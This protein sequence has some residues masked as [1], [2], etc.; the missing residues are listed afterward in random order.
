[1]VELEK[2]L[3]CYEDLGRQHEGTDWQL[4]WFVLES[5]LDS[6]HDS[7]AESVNEVNM[8]DDEGTQLATTAMHSGTGDNAEH[9][10]LAESADEDRYMSDSEAHQLNDAGPR[11][12]LGAQGPDER[13][14]SS[15]G[16]KLQC[17]L[18]RIWTAASNFH[19][20]IEGTRQSREVYGDLA[21]VEIRNNDSD[22]DQGSPPPQTPILDDAA[23]PPVRPPTPRPGTPPLGNPIMTQPAN[24]RVTRSSGH[25]LPAPREK[26]NAATKSEAA[27]KKKGSRR[28][29]AP[30]KDKTSTKGKR[31]RK[32]KGTSVVSDSDDEDVQDTSQASSRRLKRKSPNKPQ[33][34]PLLKGDVSE[35][36]SISQSFPHRL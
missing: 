9:N 22:S 25:P 21:P 17:V 31:K 30:T 33:V 14:N 10:Q 8:S 16:K 18:G 29:K 1:M 3:D 5:R 2:F 26:G 19:D 20:S 12:H 32:P 24:S 6:V 4:G 36:L 28:G 35:L 7:H 34:E 11:L 13:P 23:L 27:S 15:Q